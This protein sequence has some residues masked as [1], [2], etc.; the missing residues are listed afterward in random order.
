MRQL[1]TSR[2]RQQYL[3][4]QVEQGARGSE[5][6]YEKAKEKVLYSKKDKYSVK[7]VYYCHFGV[8]K[9]NRANVRIMEFAPR[10]KTEIASLRSQ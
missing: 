1:K 8:A 10:K 9:G 4:P 7:H 6:V 2:L 3:P 5:E